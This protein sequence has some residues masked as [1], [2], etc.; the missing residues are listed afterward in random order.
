MELFEIGD[1]VYFSSVSTLVN[2]GTVESVEGHYIKVKSR[3][4]GVKYVMASQAFHTAHELKNSKAY[5]IAWSARRQREKSVG[6]L[7]RMGSMSIF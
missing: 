1:T 4:P 5:Q 6:M 3:C 2:K 7:A